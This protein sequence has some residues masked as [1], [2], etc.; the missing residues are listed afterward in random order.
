MYKMP[1]RKYYSSSVSSVSAHASYL[2]RLKRRRVRAGSRALTAVKQLKKQFN[3]TVTRESITYKFVGASVSTAGINHNGF[4]YVGQGDNADQEMPANQRQ[5]KSIC[6]LNQRFKANIICS[7]T[8]NY[9]QMRILL[10]ESVDGNTTLSLSD[11]L[12][13]SNY[14]TVTDLVFVSP[15]KLVTGTNAKYKVH[16]DKTFELSALNTQG[17]QGKATKQISFNIK[18]GKTGKVMTYAGTTAAQPTNHRLHLFCISDSVNVT[19][20][21]ISYT[22]RS[23]YR[24]A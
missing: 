12:E 5:G 22:V 7:G 3:K 19:H 1:K 16:M 2:S 24:D 23:T 20:P 9:N 14:A 15:K 4:L 17:S 11:V 18:Y 13:Y 10:V 21:S 8:D 6:L